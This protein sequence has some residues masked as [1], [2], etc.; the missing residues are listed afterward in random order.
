MREFASKWCC[1]EINDLNRNRSLDGCPSTDSDGEAEAKEEI[2]KKLETKKGFEISTE[3]ISWRKSFTTLDPIERNH[4]LSDSIDWP[5]RKVPASSSHVGSNR[6]N[7][8][9]TSVRPW[10]RGETQRFRHM[11]R[12]C[13]AQNAFEHAQCG[14]V[15]FVRFAQ[16][17]QR[18]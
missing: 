12:V 6:K 3:S 8:A 13:H 1:G 16:R 7:K 15:I 17:G 11:N 2:E 5:Q 14:I 9:K 4:G 10:F 18:R